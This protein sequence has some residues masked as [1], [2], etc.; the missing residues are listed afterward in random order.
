MLPLSFMLGFAMGP[1]WGT[2]QSVAVDHMPSRSGV[3]ASAI[4]AIGSFGSAVNQ[5]VFGFIGEHAELPTALLY[6]AFLVVL[7]LVLLLVG[8]KLI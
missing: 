8:K 2:I 7:I 3:V 5:P 6:A 4:A 1:I